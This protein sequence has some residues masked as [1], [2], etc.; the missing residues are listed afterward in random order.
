VSFDLWLWNGSAAGASRVFDS[1]R[2]RDAAGPERP[3]LPSDELVA[4]LR[5]VFANDILLVP[6]DTGVEILGR[7]WEVSLE[8]AAASI[9]CSWSLSGAPTVIA[10]FVEAANACGCSVF[11]PQEG[12]HWPAFSVLG[13]TEDPW[14]CA[15]FDEFHVAEADDDADDDAELVRG[16]MPMRLCPDAFDRAGG[17]VTIAMELHDTV[18]PALLRP[19][20]ST[21]ASTYRQRFGDAALTVRFT[22]QAVDQLDRTEVE[23]WLKRADAT[24]ASSIEPA[25]SIAFAV[26]ANLDASEIV[27]RIDP[28]PFELLVVPKETRTLQEIFDEVSLAM[29]VV[30]PRRIVARAPSTLR[31]AL[32]ALHLEVTALA[33]RMDAGE[34]RYFDLS[35]RTASA[36][37][38][39]GW[40]ETLV[41]LNPI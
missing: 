1:M 11:D 26:A 21:R 33:E 7:G 34:V 2:I 9:A 6:F 17:T 8:G 14:A 20:V 36:G 19:F 4:S 16:A 32:A 10:S 18:E 37:L 39:L 3:P 25:T 41:G 27:A 12:A 35:G 28:C 40:L 31:S 29:F 30:V 38:N 22:G 15:F 13:R 23:G 5:S 24:P